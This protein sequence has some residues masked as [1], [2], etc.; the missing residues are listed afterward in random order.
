[1]SE[2]LRF[3]SPGHKGICLLPNGN[4]TGSEAQPRSN[5]EGTLWALSL[6]KKLPEREADYLLPST[7]VIKYEWTRT[8]SPLYA[9]M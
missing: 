1:M 2:E 8:F 3:D 5:S 6:S 4:H 7:A 9:F